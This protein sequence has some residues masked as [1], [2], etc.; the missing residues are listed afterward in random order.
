MDTNTNTAEAV[1]A[2]LDRSEIDAVITRYFVGLDERRFTDAWVR[3]IF[4]DDVR[5]TFPIGDHTGTAGLAESSRQGVAPFVRT[6]HHSTNHVIDLDGDRAAIRATLVA[7]H[8]HPPKVVASRGPGATSRFTIGAHVEGEAVRTGRGWRI[9]R[10]TMVLA[11]T[12][13][14]PPTGREKAAGQSAVG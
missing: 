8:I 13:G 4:T 1:R 5:L 2:L 6:L 10:L 12:E 11:W 9:S 7:D 14:R 3:S